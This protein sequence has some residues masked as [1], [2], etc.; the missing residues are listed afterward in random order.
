MPWWL[1]HVY[2]EAS[3]FDDAYRTQEAI[4]AMLQD[5]TEAD[6]DFGQAWVDLMEDPEEMDEEQLEWLNERA[7]LGTKLS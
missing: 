2:Y 6:P 7:P 5:T 3:D 4:G 1:M